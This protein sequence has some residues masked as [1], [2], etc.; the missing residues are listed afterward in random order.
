MSDK[1]KAPA[2]VIHLRK[3]L[4]CTLTDAER[5]ERGIALAR[6]NENIGNE[7]RRQADIKAELKATLT[8]LESERSALS[9]VVRRGEEYR[10]V[11]VDEHYDYA[12]GSVTQTRTDTG[13][14]LHRRDM[15][16]S[17]RQSF[18]P[19]GDA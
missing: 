10:D 17:E 19:L 4:P 5:L 2:T 12:H 3:N 16:E 6:V 11:D 14:Q 15:T 9:S 13:E 1:P 18:L 8:G 7:E